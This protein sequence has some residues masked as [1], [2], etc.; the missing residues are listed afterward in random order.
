MTRKQA[1]TASA[2]SFTAELSLFLFPHEEAQVLILDKKKTINIYFFYF[3][4]SMYFIFYL[5]NS[6]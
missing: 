3:I 4:T 1:I 2:A 6:D 5:L